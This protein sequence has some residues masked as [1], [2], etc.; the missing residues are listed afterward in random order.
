M[1]YMQLR[2][3]HAVATQ[4]SYTKAATALCVTQ[5]TLSDHVKALEE[6]YGVKLFERKGRGVILTGIGRALLDITRRQFSLESEAEEL[7]TTAKGLSQGELHV[8]ADGPFLVVPLLGQFHR[9]HPNIQLSMRFG[10]TQSVLNDLL[11][12]RADIAVLPDLEKDKRLYMKPLQKEQL[13]CFVNRDHAL[14]RQ[15][16]IK[17]QELASQTLIIREKGSN[18]RRVF[19]HA[20]QQA[21][22]T[23]ARYL[24]IGSREGVREAVAAGLG[25]GVVSESELGDDHRLHALRISNARPRVTEYLACLVESRPMPVVR[26]FFE[27]LGDHTPPITRT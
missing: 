8:A 27:L 5:P 24:E 15:S 14:S 7:L 6:R 26:A 16:S 10:N 21:D 17:I 12:L 2:A 23:P 11:E 25:V 18:T 20:L 13:I 4:G 9:R 1:N 19:E 22:V 3:F